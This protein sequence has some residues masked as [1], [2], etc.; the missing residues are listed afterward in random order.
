MSTVINII[1]KSKQEKELAETID[2]LHNIKHEM[3]HRMFVLATL[4]KWKEWSDSQKVRANI[5]F[6]DEM[7]KDTGDINID[8]LYELQE[9]VS[10]T[11]DKLTKS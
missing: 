11:I 6:T 1:D 4:D 10:Q 2:F 9:R 5:S 8:N 7:I 3:I